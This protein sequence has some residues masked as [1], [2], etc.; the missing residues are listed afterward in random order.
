MSDSQKDEQKHPHPS[1]TTVTQ[2]RIATWATYCDG[3]M[4]KLVLTDYR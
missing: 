1:A 4:I 3:L 2:H